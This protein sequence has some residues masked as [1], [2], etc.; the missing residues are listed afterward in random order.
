MSILGGVPIPFLPFFSLVVQPKNVI[1][2]SRRQT[3]PEIY[4]SES[5][6]DGH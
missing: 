2:T 6:P 1:D 5:P 3:L 4:E